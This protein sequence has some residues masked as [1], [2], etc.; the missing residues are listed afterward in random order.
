MKKRLRYQLPRTPLKVLR[1]EKDEKD[2]M[3]RYHE[4][5]YAP[6]TST[7]EAEADN[8]IEDDSLRSSLSR[9]DNIGEVSN[10][11]M[12]RYLGGS[13]DSIN[14]ID[15]VGDKRAQRH[16]RKKRDHESSSTSHEAIEMQVLAQVHHPPDRDSIDDEGPLTDD[17]ISDVGN[18]GSE[19]SLD[20]EHSAAHP[21]TASHDWGGNLDNHQVNNTGYQTT[22]SVSHEAIEM[23]VLAQVHNPPKTDTDDTDN[24]A[25]STE[26][27]INVSGEGLDRY[28]GIETDSINDAAVRSL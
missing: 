12:A 7:E 20:S 23:Q 14:P 4:R 22:G 16:Q 26:A 6:G 8:D 19:R 27:T 21:D 11:G 17:A 9:D 10:E 3:D 18:V 13:L 28:L 15:D 1:G 2:V 25:L 5:F 24:D